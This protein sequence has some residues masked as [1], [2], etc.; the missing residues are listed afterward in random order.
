MHPIK[1]T[2]TVVESTSGKRLAE[3][4]HTVEVPAATQALGVDMAVLN[5]SAASVE[6]PTVLMGIERPLNLPTICSNT[7]GQGRPHTAVELTAIPPCPCRVMGSGIR[8]LLPIRLIGL[9]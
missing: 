1:R 6:R 9:I 4:F 8:L 2:V 5:S 3:P 7:H